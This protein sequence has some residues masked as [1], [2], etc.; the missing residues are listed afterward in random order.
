MDAFWTNRKETSRCGANLCLAL[1][2]GVEPVL[3]V[4]VNS[5]GAVWFGISQAPQP[6]QGMAAMHVVHSRTGSALP[7]HI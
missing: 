3:L 5:T 4:N 6:F 2:A 7:P 1:H